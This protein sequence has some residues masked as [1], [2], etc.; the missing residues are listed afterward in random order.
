LELHVLFRGRKAV[1]EGWV[2]KVS[3]SVVLVAGI[4]SPP[5]AAFL[6][7]YTYATLTRASVDLN[8]DFVFRLATV[9]AVMATPF[10]VTL[11][12]AILTRRRGALRLAGKIGL[13]IAA[14]S[15]CL[16]LVPLRGLIGRAQQARNV[17]RND[18]AAPL[19]ETTDIYGKP[20]RL[21]DYA[22]K[23][24]LINAW[25]TWCLPCLEEMPQLDELYRER[26]NDGLMVFGL[27]IEDV[28]LQ[29]KFAKEKVVVSY[30]LL[31]VNGNVPG[32]YRDIQRW[33]AL[34]LVDRKGQLQPVAQ[35]GEP[36]E[37]VE[38]AVDALL[39]ADDYR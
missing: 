16:T 5:A 26:K 23:V 31:T 14:L 32:I 4:L 10:L 1:T 35:A 15:L 13:G 12:L 39:T 19:F 8:Q 11:L 9:T 38:A 29:Q 37:K 7:S 30:P 18:V 20:H 27:S 22:G 21:Q 36:F 28:A 34:F 25:A 6:G 3:N 33:P 17:S 2:A 24:V